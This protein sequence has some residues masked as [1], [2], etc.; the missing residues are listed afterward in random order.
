MEELWDP[1]QEFSRIM[2]IS[3]SERVLQVAT[4]P[5][6]ILMGHSTA[7]WCSFQM[8]SFF[9]SQLV[10]WLLNTASALVARAIL[11]IHAFSD[12]LK[13]TELCTSGK[14][15]LAWVRMKSHDK[16][17][18]E[19]HLH[20]RFVALIAGVCSLQQHEHKPS[21]PFM[22]LWGEEWVCF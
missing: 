19:G 17:S 7:E 21:S 11:F 22:G 1:R 6:A 5:S 3:T 9:L 4:V 8:G 14:N 15:R 13:H 18:Q 2:F 10:L 12:F 20:L 16:Y